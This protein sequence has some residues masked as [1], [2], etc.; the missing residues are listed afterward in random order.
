M[1][2]PCK[3]RDSL[4]AHRPTSLTSLSLFAAIAKAAV[5]KMK[6]D[7]LATSD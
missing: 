1:I 4:L 6:F 5:A 7:P 3:D 2:S